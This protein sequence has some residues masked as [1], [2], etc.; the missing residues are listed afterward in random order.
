MKG[1]VLAGGSG[2]R[3]YP[4]T[5]GVCK[6][7]LPLYDKPMV[8]YP[9]S[10]LMLAG[11][12]DI[13]VISS[14]K[15]LPMFKEMLSDGSQWGIR[16][17]YC[18]QKSPDGIAQAFLLAKEFIGNDSVCLALGDNIFFGQGF[19]PV[20]QGAAGLKEGGRIF[21]YWVRDPQRYGVVEFDDAYR[22][23]GLEEKPAVPRS[24]YAIPGL[25]FYDNNVVSITSEL[26]PSARGELE[27]TDVNREYMRR[28]KLN[29][30]LLGRGFAW[31]D[32]GTHESLLEASMFVQTIEKRQ[33]LKIACIEEIAY[34]MGY[35]D[36][37]QLLQLA[38]PLLNSGYGEYLR[39]VAKTAKRPASKHEVNNEV[40]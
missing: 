39:D 2:T 29:V 23:I 35:I 9:L 40:F 30:T 26:K 15:Y 6:Q 11:I 17:S 4:L 36:R 31:L 3:L 24:N 32:T 12:Q 20:L 19:Q 14:P 37:E 34:R 38:K 10:V 7:L 18:A 28:G 25:Y 13:M 8:Y 22:V 21:G 33:G 5:L 16:L 1:I 27:I